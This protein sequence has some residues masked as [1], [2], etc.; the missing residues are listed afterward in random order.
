MLSE[1]VDLK[2]GNWVM[3]N[4]ANSGVGGYLVQLAR[5][6]GLRTVN[7]VR[8]EGAVAAVKADGGDVVLVDG[9]DLA[10]RVKQATGGEPVR[11]G[12]DAVGGPATDRLARCLAEG[13]TLVNYGLM[14]GEPCVVSP[15]AFVFNDLTVRGFWLAKWFRV[16]TREQQR[17]LYGQLTQAMARGQLKARIHATYPVQRIQE[18]VAAAQA[19]E[20]DGKILVV[21]QG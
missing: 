9:D 14:S 5:Q 3:Q 2:P 20:R 17:A 13:G 6:R 19:G 10:Q 21:G 18:A 8:R 7:V 1:F 4:V 15:Q 16:A 11:L 12:I